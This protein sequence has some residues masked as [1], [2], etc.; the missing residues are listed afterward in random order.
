M[1]QVGF[2]RD[3]GF[4]ISASA[5]PFHRIARRGSQLLW[6]FHCPSAADQSNSPPSAIPQSLGFLQSNEVTQVGDI[7]VTQALN[8]RL[9]N[10]NLQTIPCYT[11]TTLI[12]YV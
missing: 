11:A 9:S 8:R 4:P 6:P 12:R 3:C 10:R 2:P 7:S 5:P 1:N